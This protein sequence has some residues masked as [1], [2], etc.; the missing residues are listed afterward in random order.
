MYPT[1]SLHRR[2]IVGILLVAVPGGALALDAGSVSE[3]ADG[4]VILPPAIPMIDQLLAYLDDQP[5]QS[6][7]IQIRH[8]AI[9]CAALCVRWGTYL[10]TL[11]DANA[12]LH[13][14]LTGRRVRHSQQY[15]FISDAEMQRLNI[16]VSANLARLV[17]LYREQ[18]RFAL[19]TLLA[20]AH[21]YL[22]M[23]Q[24]SVQKDAKATALIYG[25]LRAGAQILSA[26]QDWTSDEGRQGRLRPIAEGEADRFLANVLAS[27]AWRNT[28]IE[29]VHAGTRPPHPLRPQ[30]RRFLKVAEHRLLREVSANLGSV[31]WAFDDL[32]DASSR[33]GVLPAWPQTASA[34]ASTLYSGWA[35]A[36]SMRDISSPVVLDRE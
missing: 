26:A 10:A 24:Q 32:F 14:D 29:D 23:P 30:Q 27:H 11:T 2:D 3:V 20:K 34:L 25:A 16:E 22:P 21:A 12:P 4:C 33:R 8:Q 31:L 1:H 9:G 18:G 5:R 36:W 7:D 19:Y 13:P 15:S 6:S 17:R 35:T 28:T